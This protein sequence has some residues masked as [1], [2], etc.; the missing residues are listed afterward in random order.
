MNAQTRRVATYNY[1]PPG[2]Y[3]FQVI[4]CNSDGVW[5]NLGASITFEV[6]PYFWQTLQFRILAGI[7]VI[8]ASGGIV[9]FGTRRRM[10]R[11]LER[12]RT[13]AGH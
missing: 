7:M 9:W 12:H 2:Q 4:A 3:T 11:K 10:R 6:L 8:A 1:V 5:N 13:A